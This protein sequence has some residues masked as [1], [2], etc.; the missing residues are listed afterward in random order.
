MSIHGGYRN[1]SGVSPAVFSQTWVPAEGSS[2]S[3]VS[4]IPDLPVSLV[5]TPCLWLAI[6]LLTYIYT[7]PYPLPQLISLHKQGGPHT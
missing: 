2:V 7:H 5:V 3:P 6:A 4:Y 1:V